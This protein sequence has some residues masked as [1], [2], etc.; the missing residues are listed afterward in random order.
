MKHKLVLIH[1]GAANLH[2]SWK[3][4]QSHSIGPAELCERHFIP[5][6]LT[7]H[8]DQT[9]SCILGKISF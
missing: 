5:L 9:G 7:Q 8:A 6:Q 4:N 3:E 1:Q 2:N